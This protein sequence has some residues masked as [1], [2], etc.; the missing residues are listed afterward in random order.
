MTLIHKAGTAAF[1][2]GQGLRA[3]SALYASLEE[4]VRKALLDAVA[5]AKA[6]GR[7]TVLPQDI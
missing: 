4:S 5:R 3:S 1:V 7:T 6:N 2:K